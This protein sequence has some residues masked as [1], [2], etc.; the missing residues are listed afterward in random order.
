MGNEMAQESIAAAGNTEVPAF[1]TLIELGYSVDRI[2]RDGEEYWIAKKG[3]LQLMADC[4]LELLG[5]SLLRSERGPR[6][7]AT[8]NEIDEFLKRF[9]PSAVRP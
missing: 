2:D 9:Y 4:P 7:Q 1:L 3:R 5:L 8:D 6:W